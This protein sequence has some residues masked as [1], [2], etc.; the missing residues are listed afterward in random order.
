MRIMTFSDA[1]NEAIHEEMVRGDRIFL[2]GE[3][4]GHAWR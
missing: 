3:A 1:L 4:C 2:I